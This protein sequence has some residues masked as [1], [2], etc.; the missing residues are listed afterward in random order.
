MLLKKDLRE[1]RELINITLDRFLPRKD[2][3]PKEIHKAVRHTLFAGGKRLRPYLTI[4]TFMLFSDDIDLIRPVGAAVELLHTYTLVHDDLPEID[5]DEYRRGRKT[6]HIVYGPDL[7]LLAG[8]ALLT[9]AFEMLG[10]C[11]LSV[12][13][14]L[15]LIKELAAEAGDHGL[16]AG[17][18]MDIE[19]EGKDVT[20]NQLRFIHEN[21]TGRLIRL[22]VRF[23]CYV[24]KANETD[25]L[26]MEQFGD[27]LGLAFQIIDDILDIE[28]DT[29]KLGKSVGKDREVSKATYP[30][31]YG[32]EESREMARKLIDEAKDLLAPFGE[33]AE[34]L[35][36]L[37]DFVFT[38]DF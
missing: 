27:K 5:N 7:A 34:V 18:M 20:S 32:I 35:R 19:C 31:V 36:M 29:K 26:R 14:K 1:K 6:C 13:L 10:T 24:G 11:D 23:G 12:D 8:D 15:K 3:Y 17:Q 28:G 37:A 22:A 25:T 2:E 4:S 16:I 30:A 33:E 38:R 21:K 9:Y